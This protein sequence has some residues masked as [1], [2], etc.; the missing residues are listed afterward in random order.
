MDIFRTFFAIG[1]FCHSN[2]CVEDTVS[3]EKSIETLIDLNLCRDC[4]FV[5][6]FERTRQIFGHVTSVVFFF[7]LF[8][9][10]DEVRGQDEGSLSVQAQADGL[11]AHG[12]R[13]GNNL[14]TGSRDGHRRAG[15]DANIISQLINKEFYFFQL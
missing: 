9:I 4:Y 5:T 12:P 3:N 14:Q 6:F 1:V 11:G 8:R 13:P 10:R 7:S 15:S 2:G